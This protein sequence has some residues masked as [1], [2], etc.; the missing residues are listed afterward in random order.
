METDRVTQKP[1]ILAID[2]DGVIHRNRD[3][4]KGGSIYD[5]PN[6]G[7]KETLQKLLDLGY[8]IL[9]HS[10]RLHNRVFDGKAVPHQREEI[11]E[12]WTKHNLV[13]HENLDFH[14]SPGKPLAHL[15]LDDKACLF[16]D[17]SQALKDILGRLPNND[18]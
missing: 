13:Q 17:W 10:V 5:E 8:H 14:T 7:T 12:W 6:P 2:F 1:Y 15:Y 18:R 11:F 4:W 3:G 16:C 9:I